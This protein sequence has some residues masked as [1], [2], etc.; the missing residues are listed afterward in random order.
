MQLGHKIGDRAFGLIVRKSRNTGQGIID[1]RTPYAY[2]YTGVRS[3]ARLDTER[4][5]RPMIDA[6]YEFDIDQPVM[7]ST[8]DIPH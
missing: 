5:R 8:P 3:T 2:C 4:L 7:L 1:L 6:P